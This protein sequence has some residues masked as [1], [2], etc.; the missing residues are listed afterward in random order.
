M[1]GAQRTQSKRTPAKG[2][3]ERN[4]SSKAAAKAVLA[5]RQAKADRR[6]IILGTVAVIV[7][8]LIV[9]GGV[10]ITNYNSEQQK[11]V[12]IPAVQA[13]PEY[14]AVLQDDGT[15]M[16][17]NPNAKV[18][19]DAYEDFICS[20]CGAVEQAY[21]KQIIKALADGSIKVHDRMV[22]IL[23]SLSK[24]PGYSLLA[25]NAALAAAK[26]GKFADF[27][28]SLYSAQP[29]EN[30]EGYTAD[31]LVSL[32]QRLGI[33]GDQFANDVRNGAYNDKIEKYTSTATN[34]PSL[35]RVCDNSGQKKFCTPIIM[36]NGKF[37]DYAN[38]ANWLSDLINNSKKS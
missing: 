11:L 18:T 5:A 23:D 21:G 3:S 12:S 7:V 16:A 26:A 25:A 27:H 35:Q 29:K 6:N 33:T 8:A 15:V 22:N 9:I 10:L 37:V 14:Q 28:T 31:Q 24:P 30:S 20:G 19:I 2:A 36:V 13:S 34:D 17:G 32:G 38:N 4:R 1:G